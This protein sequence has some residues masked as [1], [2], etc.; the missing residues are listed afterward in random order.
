MLVRGPL[1]VFL[2]RVGDWFVGFLVALALAG[3][4]GWPWLSSVAFVVCMA[5]VG[6]VLHRTFVRPR[7]HEP[8]SAVLA[9]LTPQEAEKAL[10]L[11]ADVSRWVDHVCQEAP[12]RRRPGLR[13]TSGCIAYD[14]MHNTVLL[15][16]GHLLRLERRALAVVLAHE[17]GHCRRRWGTLLAFSEWRVMG[18]ELL[19]DR[20]SL[21]VTG[22]TLA[23]WASACVAVSSLEGEPVTP[24]EVESGLR[25]SL[26]QSWL[27]ERKGQ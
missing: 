5:G 2:M 10:S 6:A 3:L 8:Q 26:L 7:W 21:A 25:Y 1:V 13:L 9:G 12:V 19:A 23:E 4:I 22:A 24:A 17:L 15:P 20:F 14:P 18:E 11:F 27:E 16:V